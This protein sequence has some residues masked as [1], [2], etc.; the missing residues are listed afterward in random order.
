[1]SIK[2]Q[3]LTMVL[4]NTVIQDILQSSGG[5]I[6][7][8]TSL[9]PDLDTVDP[10]YWKFHSPFGYPGDELI[11]LEDYAVR[12]AGQN[13]TGFYAVI[14]YKDG[15]QIKKNVSAPT[16]ITPTG[17]WLNANTMPVCYSRCRVLIQDIQM[18]PDNSEWMFIVS[19]LTLP[20]IQFGFNTV[21]ST[22]G[23]K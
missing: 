7:L 23:C 2:K 15:L 16:A 3:V 5:T 14:E 12:E 10:Q 20:S 11:I 6:H 9:Y 4:T 19:L 22:C 8:S 18:A 13:N 17:S 21:S 1:M